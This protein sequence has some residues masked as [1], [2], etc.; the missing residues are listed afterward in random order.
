MVSHQPH[1][2]WWLVGMTQLRAYWQSPGGGGVHPITSCP[3]VTVVDLD[4]QRVPPSL[5]HAHLPWSAFPSLASAVQRRT[6]SPRE[7][8][9]MA[10]SCKQLTRMCFLCGTRSSMWECPRVQQMAAM[11]SLEQLQQLRWLEW[12]PAGDCELAVL[13]TLTRLRTLLVLAHARGLCLH[14][15]VCVALGSWPSCPGMRTSSSAG[16]LGVRWMRA[17]PA[18]WLCRVWSSLA[19]SSLAGESRLCA[20]IASSLHCQAAVTDAYDDNGTTFASLLQVSGPT[21]M[22]APWPPAPCAAAAFQQSGSAPFTCRCGARVS[23]RCRAPRPPR[24]WWRY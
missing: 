3:R 12:A 23:R 15:A 17:G 8:E 20:S 21:D 22:H 2:A 24:R 13:A 19:A 10:T 5:E 4:G 18:G 14:A 7:F 9:S 16:C 6:S 11:R 1:W